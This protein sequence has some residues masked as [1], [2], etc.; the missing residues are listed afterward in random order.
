M[1][2][3][4]IR[5]SKITWEDLSFHARFDKVEEI[6]RKWEE[7]R[8][9]IQSVERAREAQRKAD[10]ER[11]RASMHL[12]YGVEVKVSDVSSFFYGCKGKVNKRSSGTITVIFPGRDQREVFDHT[13]LTL[14][15]E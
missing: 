10:A 6:K 2:L 9:Y 1:K 14:V 13:Q 11:E 15:Y 5:R 4:W 7:D 3:P 8:D 12:T